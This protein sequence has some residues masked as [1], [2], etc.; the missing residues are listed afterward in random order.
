[1][2]KQ[3]AKTLLDLGKDERLVLLI[4][5][6]SHYLLKDFED[7]YKDRFYNMGVAEQAMMSIASG[8]A[9]NGLFPVVH[10]IT[11]FVVER[12]FEQIKDDLCYQN[13]GVN[14]VSVGG[15]FDYAALGCTHHCY[16]DFALMRVLP[17]MQV[18]YPA[19][20]HE[21]DILFRQTFANGSPTYFRL[22]AKIHFLPTKPN[23]GDVEKLKEGKE[24][25]VVA[26]GPQLQNAY[27]AIQELEKE[28]I[29]CDLIY[30]TT[31]KPV[32]EAAKAAITASLKKTK[33]LLTIEEH[34][35]IGGV[36]D[37]VALIASNISFGHHRLGI[38]DKFLT[39][40]GTY[41]E[42]CEANGLTKSGIKK[43]IYEI[44]SENNL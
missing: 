34:S 20:P 43:A 23:F 13:L 8:L 18:I 16:E 42:H 15:A 36:G 2:R 33:R 6:I 21:F 44:K 12:C 37:T 17:N 38:K 28:S 3:F 32:S 24:V 19:S 9:I 7:K 29:T 4:G 14:I 11:P 31:L 39:N 27:D 10:S 35:V 22:P 40:Y 26:A 41:E 25:T 5:D 30:M 1:M